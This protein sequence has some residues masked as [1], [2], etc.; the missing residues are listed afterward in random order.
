MIYQKTYLALFELVAIYIFQNSC[1]RVIEICRVILYNSMHSVSQFV[2]L[3]IVNSHAA[4]NLNIILFI[5][6]HTICP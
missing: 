4:L 5:L 3:N 2:S 1:G 6:I